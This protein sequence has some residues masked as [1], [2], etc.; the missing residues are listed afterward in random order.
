MRLSK[1]ARYGRFLVGAAVLFSLL[2]CERKRPRTIEEVVAAAKTVQPADS[3]V[4]TSAPIAPLITREP[5]IEVPRR[6]VLDSLGPVRLI[7]ALLTSANGST[8]PN[9][10]IAPEA[11]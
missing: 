7:A 10:A 9:G 5:D 8:R 6:E 3:P 4:V 11:K 1:T 2:A